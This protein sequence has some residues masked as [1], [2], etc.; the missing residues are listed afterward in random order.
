MA[1]SNGCGDM[2]SAQLGGMDWAALVIHLAWG[3]LWRGIEVGGL[4]IGAFG[5][6]L[7]VW[8]EAA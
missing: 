8:G 3:R 1:A 7:V 2:G 5:V 4:G 6:C